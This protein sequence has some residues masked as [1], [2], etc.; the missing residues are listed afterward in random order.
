MKD[1]GEPLPE[2]A[3]RYA[4]DS[5]HPRQVLRLSIMLFD[6]LRTLHGLGDTER[7]WL[8]AAAILHDIGWAYGQKGHH[9]RSLEMI[10]S[11]DA[12]PFD[13][14]TRCI[15]GLIARYHR[16]ALPAMSHP[17]FADLDAMDRDRVRALAALL[18]IADGLDV[19][20]SSLV[21]RLACR[22]TDTA[23][24]VTCTAPCPGIAEEQSAR[25]RSDL[26]KEFF[27]L[28]VVIEWQTGQGTQ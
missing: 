17:W 28:D 12:L 20:H 11:D 24:V 7:Q 5:G 16:K 22:R 13:T 1:E 9:K 19:T 2:Y 8:A 10:L 21:R 4:A 27:G 3:R 26:F 18:R 15:V 14:R 25:K 6:E 23:L